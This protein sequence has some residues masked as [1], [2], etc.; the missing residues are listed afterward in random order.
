MSR[1]QEQSADLARSHAWQY[2]RNNWHT[3]QWKAIPDEHRIPLGFPSNLGMYNG[4]LC[5]RAGSETM[6][7]AIQWLNRTRKA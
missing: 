5:T 7:A 2:I 4:N 3:S 1:I 6:Q